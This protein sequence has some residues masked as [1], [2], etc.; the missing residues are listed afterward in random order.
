MPSS[1]SCFIIIIFFYLITNIFVCWST[2]SNSNRFLTS[3]WPNCLYVNCVPCASRIVGCT[4]LRV[5]SIT[6]QQVPLHIFCFLANTMNASLTLC[7]ILTLY[8]FPV[9]MLCHV[10]FYQCVFCLCRYFS[11]YTYLINKPNLAHS[12]PVPLCVVKMW[13]WKHRIWS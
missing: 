7:I 3:T 1:C 8:N 13:C 5:I 6:N 11:Q 9:Y 10:L 2:G 4:C 12:W